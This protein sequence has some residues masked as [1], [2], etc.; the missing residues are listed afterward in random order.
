MS[1]NQ[2]DALES[3]LAAIGRNEAL[4]E[5]FLTLLRK[6]ESTL[7]KPDFSVR[8]EITAPIIDALH[9]DVGVLTR[10]LEGGLVFDFHY[11]SKIARELVMCPL[12]KP[13]HVW[14]PQTTKLLVHLAKG[15][16]HAIIGGAYSGDQAIF[17]AHTMQASGGRCHAFEP[18]TDQRAML[19][20]NAANNGLD[21]IAVC[22][23]GLW[24]DED[25]SMI[26]VG[27][28][29]FAHPEIVEN[30]NGHA[31]D[32]VF[33]TT[34]IDAYCQREKIEQLDLIMLDIEGAEFEA[35]RGAET[36]LSRPGDQ[37][38]NVVFE[39]HRHYVDWS[40]GL[41]NTEIVLFMA[42]QG[43]HLYAVRDFNSNVAMNGAPVEL[44]PVDQVY[45]EGP[46]HGFNMLAVKSEA[47]VASDLFRICPG[48]SPKLLSHRD[49][50]LHHPLCQAS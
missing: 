36:A 20:R 46:P 43:Y 27:D 15:A 30:G 31:A 25:A 1:D 12:S 10:G 13:D 18:N 47:L 19:E 11:R 14:E 49:P 37:A 41:E 45:L 16:K 48:V 33:R 8:D 29:S 9:E 5:E 21:N 22:G 44:V 35:L 23:L 6:T 42:A 34:S 38:P 3:S 4:R 50:K 40:E 28:D 39:I 32:E 7:A 2:N 26:L 17:V 24:C